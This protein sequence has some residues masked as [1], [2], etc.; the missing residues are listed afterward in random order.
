MLAPS[1]Q[2]EAGRQQPSGDETATLWAHPYCHGG[3]ASRLAGPFGSGLSG[4][5]SVE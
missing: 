5:L 2:D 3:C 1:Q 4:R